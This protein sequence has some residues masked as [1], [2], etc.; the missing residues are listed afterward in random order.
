MRGYLS[1]KI[2]I[3]ILFI[4]TLAFLPALLGHYAGIVALFLLALIF[5]LRKNLEDSF[6]IYSNKK[7]LFIF[8]TIY[9]ILFLNV[10]FTAIG[11]YKYLGLDEGYIKNIIKIISI[12]L[13]LILLKICGINIKNF[14]WSMNRGQI[15]GTLMIGLMYACIIIPLDGFIFIN[16]FNGDIVQYGFFILNTIILVAFFE[17]F[18][19]RGILISALKGYQIAEWKVNII[20]ALLFGILHCVKYLDKGIG[21]A[22]LITGYQTVIGYFFGKLYL[23]TKT[24]TPSILI[25]LL[26]DI[27]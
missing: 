13:S 18:L 20:Q 25:H 19:C 6:E 7:L 26:W 21:I 10:F 9:S 11:L 16:R 2:V 3:E 1:K 14:K 24:L 5:L 8:I 17:E 27:L 22:L 15:I 12:T 23:K 4:V